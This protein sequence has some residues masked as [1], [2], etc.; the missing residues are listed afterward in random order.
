MHFTT[1]PSFQE[2][3][4]NVIPEEIFDKSILS[5]FF[6]KVNLNVSGCQRIYFKSIKTWL[7]KLAHVKILFNTMVKR[8]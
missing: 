6:K 3:D 2:I 8:Q 1:K 4:G 5:K 7:I